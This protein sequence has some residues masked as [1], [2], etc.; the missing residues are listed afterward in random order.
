MESRSFQM[1]T[2]WNIIYYPEK[3]TGFGVLVIGDE[4]HFVEEGKCFWTQNEGKLVIIDELKEMGYTIFSSNLYG[5]NWGSARAADLAQRLYH[6]VIRSEI[7][8]HKIHI[9]AEGMG[10]LIA[11]QLMKKMKENIRSVLL[12]NPILSLKYHLEQEK[13]HKFFYKKL[14]RELMDAYQ[15]DEIGLNNLISKMEV[16]IQLEDG[17]PVH[18]IHVLSGARSYNQSKQYQQILGSSPINPTFLLPEKKL[19]LGKICYKFFKSHESV[20]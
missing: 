13:E 15:L 9:L 19:Q 11:I 16:P 17:I 8:N 4:R 20:L 12:L 5:R 6:Q 18:I 14:T 10:A 2:Q 1:D 3:P 7:L